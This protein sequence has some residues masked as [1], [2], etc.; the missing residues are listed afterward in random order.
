MKIIMI[1]VIFLLIILYPYF[2]RGVDELVSDIILFIT[3][4]VAFILRI[5]VKTYRLC[6][7][8]N[9]KKD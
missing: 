3:Y 5:I 9:S 6:K 8:K 1:L 2:K 4:I 7:R